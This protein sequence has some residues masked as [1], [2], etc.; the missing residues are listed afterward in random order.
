MKTILVIDDD[1]EL[2]QALT[3]AL[4]N[5][6]WKVLSASNGDE[7]LELARSHLPKAILCD[8][9]M[10]GKNGFR[11]CSAI[12]DD[13]ALKYSVL[14]AMS[15][16]GFE[17][18]KQA[19]MEAGADEFMVK[20][21]DFGRLCEVLSHIISRAEAD[22][23]TAAVESTG[24]PH[25]RFWGVRGSIPTPGQDTVR[26]GGNTACV[27]F[28]G[29]GE[30]II[31]DAGTG[32]RNLGSSLAAEFAGKALG[33]TLLIT[34]SHW[35]HVHGFPFFQ[36]AYDPSNRIRVLGF[37]G[38]REGLAGVFSAQ[39]E[40]PF[41]PIGL[42]QIPSHLSFEELRSMEFAIGNVKVAVAFANHPGVCVGYRL[43]TGGASV[44]Y[45]PDHEP[46]HRMRNQSVI[47]EALK[48]QTRQFALAEDEKIARF[49]EG[50]DVLILD[51]Q[52]DSD[53]YANHTG[54]GHSSVDD[55]V[56]LALRSKVK[57]LFLF[58]HDPSHNDTKID[59]MVLHARAL[60]E[61]AGGNLD[62]EAAR[63]GYK[64]ELIPAK[65]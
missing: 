56:E 60:V 30:I 48:D 11:V 28:R 8:L 36:P 27:E 6:G 39:M 49:L 5:Q 3:A 20:P 19:A 22:A 43:S 12:R 51:A 55:A 14:I 38:T 52:F 61:K 7:G 54:W 59:Q 15:G 44:A 50:T 46:F 18:T 41:F 9:L 25:V 33:L 4:E 26:Y 45:L 58:H 34:H 64:C 2:R 32:I 40:S 65:H 42:A 31:L 17:D 1:K 21:L 35:D 47:P 16:K 13:D 23:P 62:V 53:E 24:S 29:G 37:E 57:K 10:P 63:E